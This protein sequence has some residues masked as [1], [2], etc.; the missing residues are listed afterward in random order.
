[1]NHQLNTEANGNRLFDLSFIE[2][3]CR[4][5]A[6][7]K[8]KMLTTF[9]STIPFSVEEIRKAYQ[10]Q[11]F[12]TIKNTAHQIK[13]VLAF[14]AIVTLEKDIEL[15][16]QLAN[17]AQNTTELQLKIQKLD[18]VVNKVVS[19]IKANFLNNKY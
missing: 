10:Q 16:E 9:I 5:N 2:K 7:T 4:N 3:V 19:Q 8:R 12:V 14:Y 18:E 1:M 11:D 13:P 15:I 6:E 17:K